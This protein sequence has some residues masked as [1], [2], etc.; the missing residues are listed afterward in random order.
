MPAERIIERQQ[1]FNLQEDQE[2][3]I[4]NQKGND[5]KASCRIQFTSENQVILQLLQSYLSQ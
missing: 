4:K 2:R 1:F 5:S 3:K